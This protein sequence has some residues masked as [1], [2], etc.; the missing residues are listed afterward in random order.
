MEIHLGFE[1][2]T[3]EPV[4]IPLRHLVATGI[5]RDSGKTTTLWAL[6]SRLPEGFRA[7]AFRTKRGEL[8]FQGANLVPPFYRERCDWR[9]VES[10]LEAAMK[11][12]L[13]FERSWIIRACKGARTL[14]QVYRNITK[15]LES[16]K[17]LRGLD[18]S[19]WTNLQ[20]YFDEVLPQLEENPF[21]DALELAPGP[22]VMNLGHLGEEVQA[23]VISSCLERLSER[24]SDVVVVIPEA[25]QFVPQRRG[26]PVKWAAQ[27]VIRM[28]AV[29][30]LLM[31]LDSQDVTGIDKSVLKS[32]GTWLLGRQMELNEVKR[33]IDQLPTR[34]RPKPEQVM[35]LPVGHFYAASD[36]WCRLV[37]V[38][39]A[40]L[41]DEEARRV[42]TGEMEVPA[43]P[44]QAVEE[45]DPMM[46]AELQERLAAA[47]S[48]AEELQ[49]QVAGLQGE[50][51]GLEAQLAEERRMDETAQETLASV[52]AALRDILDLAGWAPATS[53][54]Q[55]G[56]DEIVE[57]VLA[58]LGGHAQV[59][60]V[61]PPE[62]LKHRFQEEALARLKAEVEALEPRE[63]KIV[64]WL[65][66]HGN[67]ATT[68]DLALH[69]EGREWKRGG[70][71]AVEFPNVLKGLAGAG[72]IRDIP[73]ARYQPA[74]RNRVAER[75]Q[76][77]SPTAEDAEQVYQH[78]L[79]L[80][81][82]EGDRGE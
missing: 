46:I 56:A 40:W 22:N 6:L 12:R 78:L 30:R 37:Y 75:L 8:D 58:R 44:V 21:S 73:G 80:L 10:L 50:V 66:Q 33:V 59:V 65:E 38:Q 17:R 31:W 2:G 74:L 64:A 27:R 54:T 43:P 45:E 79:Y 24:E 81:A 70:R 7:L 68:T 14:R 29:V 36:R 77:Y 25:W 57:K 18:E 60:Q 82:M 69:V 53:S 32:V 13:K 47:E 39:P 23:L 11:E 76:P 61:T 20:A 41:S 28:G 4:S 67:T 16:G 49:E 48:R 42:A 15:Q 63:R 26:G 52:Q 3:G 1:V 35:T 19:V 71:Y 9:Y 55:P 62:A 51:A 34:E 5:T 72:L